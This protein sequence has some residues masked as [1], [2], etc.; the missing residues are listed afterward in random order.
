MNAI[1]CK[2]KLDRTIVPVCDLLMARRGGVVLGSSNT[3]H[4]AECSTTSLGVQRHDM[5]TNWWSS[6]SRTP[7]KRS[8]C[9]TTVAQHQERR[10]GLT[11]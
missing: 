8:G 2:D 4:I 10:C 11:Q 9:R 3:Y 6:F 5:Q 1:F 7:H